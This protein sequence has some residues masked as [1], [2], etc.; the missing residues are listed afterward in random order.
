MKGS[1]TMKRFKILGIALLVVALLVSFVVYSVAQDKNKVK[2]VVTKS[3]KLQKDSKIKC[4]H[5]CIKCPS[6]CNDGELMDVINEKVSI[7]KT[8]TSSKADHKCLETCSKSEC[9][10]AKTTAECKEKHAKGECKGH[11]PKEKK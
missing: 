6:K 11:E 8:K 10:N 4:P 7:K 9:C 5:S 2:K 1:S 3:E